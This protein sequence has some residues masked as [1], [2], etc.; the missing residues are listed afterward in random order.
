MELHTH[1]VQNYIVLVMVNSP[2]NTQF[3]IINLIGKWIIIYLYD[4]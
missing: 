4:Y 1:I 3:A 2:W